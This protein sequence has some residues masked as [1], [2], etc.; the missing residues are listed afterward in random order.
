MK[1]EFV[2]ISR[3]F[4]IRISVNNQFTVNQEI[5]NK[6]KLTE[7]TFK[8]AVDKEDPEK[9]F[10]Y[11]YL[12]EPLEGGGIKLKKN[13]G[14]SHQFNSRELH[15]ILLREDKAGGLKFC[16]NIHEGNKPYMQFEVVKDTSEKR[17]PFQE[18]GRAHV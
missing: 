7:R 3:V 8:W 10:V 4:D 5:V 17:L 9:K 18:I 15:D 14:G 2:Q 6:F 1:L 12:C 16:R 11:L 13:A